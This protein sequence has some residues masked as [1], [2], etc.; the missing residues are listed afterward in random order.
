M[1]CLSHLC[2]HPGLLL[3]HPL[4]GEHLHGMTLRREEEKAL[5]CGGQGSKP[6]PPHVTGAHS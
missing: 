6:S 5:K 1:R 4:A 2:P 3:P